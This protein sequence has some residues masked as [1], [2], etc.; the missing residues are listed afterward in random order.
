MALI[1]FA[2]LFG[3]GLGRRAGDAGG[4]GR[5]LARVQVRPGR[6]ASPS[7][8]GGVPVVGAIWRNMSM[9]EFLPPDGFARRERSPPCRGGPARGVGGCRPDRP[10]GGG[11]RSRP[12]CRPARCSRRR[13]PASAGVFPFG[14]AS[15][16]GPRD[17]RGWPIVAHRGRDV[18]GRARTQA[19]FAGTILNVLV[20]FSVLFGASILL[21]GLF[22]P[23]ITLISKLSGDRPRSTCARS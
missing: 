19:T 14:R 8:L 2:N 13:W 17:T 4:R 23:M 1:A 9:A 10:A 11:A 7:F 21:L 18:R 16:N 3:H 6:A 5:L 12:R 22:L 20:V 15:S